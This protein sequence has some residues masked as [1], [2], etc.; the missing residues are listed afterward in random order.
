[1]AKN[2]HETLIDYYQRRPEANVDGALVNINAPSHINVFYLDG[3]H[4]QGEYKRRNFY[5]VVLI[6]NKS[7]V[8]I[9][10]VWYHLKQPALIFSTP[11]TPYEWR[12][13]LNKKKA[14]ICVFT[15]DFLHTHQYK[16]SLISTSLMHFKTNPVFLLTSRQR[17][18][19]INIFIKMKAELNADYP[20]KNELLRNY[21]S[22]LYHFGNKLSSIIAKKTTLTASSR[23]TA[24]FLDLLNQQFPI[25]VPEQTLQLKS[26]ADFARYLSVHV[27]YLNR[28]VMETTGKTTTE[29]IA[30]RL[31][32]EGISMLHNTQLSIAQIAYGLSFEDAAYFHRFFK[33]RYGVS[34][35]EVRK[36]IGIIYRH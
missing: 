28:S 22:I 31:V 24:A 5:I 16:E 25:P 4:L 33:K 13:Y 21:L 30:Q 7:S 14:W 12:S 6:L 32:A 29:L 34:P 17:K 8:Q 9:N 20:L 10:G 3:Y 27:N 23:L 18:E 2:R 15:E 19:V 26:A 36:Q 1:M 35:G 11:A